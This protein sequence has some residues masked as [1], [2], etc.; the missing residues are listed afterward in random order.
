M[1]YLWKCTMKTKNGYLRFFL[2]FSVFFLTFVQNIYFLLPK[3]NNWS[4]LSSKIK[5]KTTILVNF[6]P[7]LV[8]VFSEFFRNCGPYFYFSSV[9]SL[10]ATKK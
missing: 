10:G 7:N 1:N 3:N 8:C 5:L 4:E 2:F 9:S 6:K